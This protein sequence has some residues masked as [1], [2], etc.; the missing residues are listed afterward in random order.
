MTNNFAFIT[1]AS[2]L[3]GNR[4]NILLRNKGFTTI[5]LAHNSI[6]LTDIVIHDIA[7]LASITHQVAIILNLAGAPIA[8]GRWTLARK[9]ILETSRIKLTA[10]L[11]KTLVKYNIRCDHF[12]SGSAIGYY[13]TG[14][15]QFDETSPKGSDFS[16]HLCQRWEDEAKQSRHVTPVTTILRTGLVLADK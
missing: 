12:I 13:G 1:G 16:A 10:S 9:E 2:G 5:G 11:V 15:E 8:N 3:L 7:E 14:K 4:A 6:P